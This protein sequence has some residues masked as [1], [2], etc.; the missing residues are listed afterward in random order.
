MCVKHLPST[1]RGKLKLQIKAE[2]GGNSPNPKQFTYMFNLLK[3]IIQWRATDILLVPK[4]KFWLAEFMIKQRSAP[5]GMCWCEKYHPAGDG[6][7][8]PTKKLIWQQSSKPRNIPFLNSEVGPPRMAQSSTLRKGPNYR[9]HFLGALYPK[10]LLLL[11]LHCWWSSFI[12]S[13]RHQSKQGAW[14]WSWMSPLLSLTS[15][16]E[17]NDLV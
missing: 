5:T 8:L 12:R 1:Q 9:R 6:G 10:P 15:I 13:L 16:F 4:G 11:L 7:T 17:R 3:S 2:G 14:G